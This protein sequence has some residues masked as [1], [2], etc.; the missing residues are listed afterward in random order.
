MFDFVFLVISLLFIFLVVCVHHYK[1]T[2]N[3]ISEI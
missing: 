3:V 2:L 1:L